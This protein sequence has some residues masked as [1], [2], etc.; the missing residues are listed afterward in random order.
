MELNGIC[1]LLFF[2]IL[3]ACLI[4]WLVAWPFC[5]IILLRKQI[6]VSCALIAVLVVLALI[7]VVFGLWNPSQLSRPSEDYFQYFL[8]VS[9][10]L[11]PSSLAIGCIEVIIKLALLLRVKFPNPASPKLREIREIEGQSLF[12]GIK[13]ALWKAI[14]VVFCVF[15][16]R[17]AIGVIHS[18]HVYSLE[19]ALRKS[20]RMDPKN[21]L[22]IEEVLSRNGIDYNWYPNGSLRALVPT[23]CPYSLFDEYLYIEINTNKDLITNFYINYT[24][25]AL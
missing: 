1:I 4:A 23:K 7:E 21:F 25:N 8:Q 17:F 5:F 6:P 3:D 22:K 2:R 15:A 11:S 16:A 13:R 20:L 14:L 10:Y 24:Y 9:W 18:Q 19:K 12:H